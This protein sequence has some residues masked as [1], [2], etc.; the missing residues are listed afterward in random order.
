M[1]IIL[2]KKKIFIIFFIRF[3]P[4]L[5]ESSICKS[6][7]F[8][9]F[10][11]LFFLSRPWL[12]VEPQGGL[13]A[14]GEKLPIEFTIQVD[15]PTAV[16]LNSGAEKLEDILILSIVDGIDHFVRIFLYP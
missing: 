6:E 3:T 16:L 9:L 15:P 14:P 12:V 10:I 4:K 5:E 1:I 8:I 13:I 7:Y 11:Y 2:L